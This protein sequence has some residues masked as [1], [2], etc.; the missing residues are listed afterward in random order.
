MENPEKWVSH[1]LKFRDKIKDT[2][3]DECLWIMDVKNRQYIVGSDGWL[4][5]L[6]PLKQN[7]NR[8]KP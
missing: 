1:S 2:R 3:T 8:S 4:Y 6:K 7:M 5:R